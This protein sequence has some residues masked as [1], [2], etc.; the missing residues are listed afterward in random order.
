MQWIE[1]ERLL[2]DRERLSP[3]E[4][5]RLQDLELEDDVLSTR[6]ANYFPLQ[7]LGGWLILLLILGLFM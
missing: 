4:Q 3:S 7:I 1:Y 6:I 2:R 5:R